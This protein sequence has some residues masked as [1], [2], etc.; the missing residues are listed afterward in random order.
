[1]HEV[2][3]VSALLVAIPLAFGVHFLMGIWS[4]T[5][6]LALLVGA[7]VIIGVAGGLLLLAAAMM[8]PRKLG[9]DG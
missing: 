2:R 7:L 3:W 1:M 8:A 4:W 9:T 5:V 6:A